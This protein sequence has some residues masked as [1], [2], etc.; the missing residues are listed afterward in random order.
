M[1]EWDVVGEEPLG[2]PEKQ[3]PNDPWAVVEQPKPQSAQPAAI[4][5]AGRNPAA[6]AEADRLAR[7]AG[8]PLSV[9]ERNPQ[10]LKRQSL[11][12]QAAE[13]P[14][15]LTS[16]LMRDPD[17]AAVSQDDWGVLSVLDTALSVNPFTAPLK[18]GMQIKSA[19]N[20]VR[21]GAAS[22]VNMAGSAIDGLTEIP[23]WQARQMER[24]TVGL[25]SVFSDEWA[26]KVRDN[27]DKMNQDYGWLSIANL[28]KGAGDSVG[29]AVDAYAK[30]IDVP[31]A[32]RDWLDELGAGA[33]SLLA[34]LGAG[35]TTG[36]VG[37]AALGA[38]VGV[39]QQADE[40]DAA[41]LY[42]TEQADKAMALGGAVSAVSESLGF[43]WLTRAIPEP[44]KKYLANRV[45]DIIQSGLGEGAQEVIENASQN[46]ITQRLI[47]PNQPLLEGVGTGASVGFTL[48]A[49][50]RGSQHVAHK[51][52]DSQSAVVENETLKEILRVSQS[53]KLFQMSPERY[54]DAVAALK[55]KGMEDVFVPVTEWRELFQSQQENDDARQRAGMS[56]AE[57]TAALLSN[58]RV[59]IPTESLMSDF[60]PEQQNALAKNARFQPDGIIPEEA[61]TFD[62]TAAM[63]EY[64]QQ[65]G[66]R[67][68]GRD[69]EVYDEFV[70]RLTGPYKRQEAEAMAEQYAGFV[71]GYGGRT[72]MVDYLVNA[73]IE[74]T[75]LKADSKLPDSM[76]KLLAERKDVVPAV[77]SILD[78]LRDR[79]FPSD[80]EMF[81]PT[82]LEAVRSWGGIEPTSFG[83]TDLAAMDAKR[84]QL[85]RSSDIGG[86]TMEDALTRAVAEGFINKRALSEMDQYDADAADIN[87]LIEALT[88]DLQGVNPVYS[89]QNANAA[90]QE[91]SRAAEDLAR[92]LNDKGIDLQKVDNATAR[93]M[94][95]WFTEEQDGGQ[96]YEQSD[97]AST[98]LGDAVTVEVDGIE[99]PAMNSN[100]VPIHDTV[101]G[102]RN[103]WRWFG[104]SKAVDA[105]G[106]PLV[107]YHGSSS[108]FERF[109]ESDQYYLTDDPGIA[110]EYADASGDNPNVMPLYS[111][112]KTP[113]EFD[114]GGANWANL[115]PFMVG[116][117]SPRVN[118]RDGT[119][120]LFDVADAA[121]AAGYDSV[122][123]KNVRDGNGEYGWNTPATV[124]IASNNRQMKSAT[125]NNGAFDPNNP[126]I[127]YQSAPGFDQTQTPEFKAWSNDA[128]LIKS[129]AAESYD[130]KTGEKI[131]VEAFHG[132]KRPDRVGVKF[133]KKRATSGPMAFHTSSPEVAS[134]YAQGKQDTSIAYEDTDYAN[135]FKVKLPGER[136]S[137]DIIRAWYGLSPEQK[138][139]IAEM[140]PKLT[141]GEE[142]Y[143]ADGNYVETP[144][145]V[146]EGNTQGLGGYD[147]EI[148]RTRTSW[149]R[150]GNPLKALVEG[151]LNGGS[152]FGQEDRFLKVLELAGFPMNTVTYDSPTSE[153]PFVYKN[154]IAMQNPLVT[155][156]IPQNVMDALQA[157]AK[158]DRSRA[159]S[160]GADMWDKNTRTL[161]EWV[162]HLTDP[163]NASVSYVWTSIP[164]K[165]TDVFRSLGY[166]GIVDWSGKSG[167]SLVAPVYIPFNETQ[168]K[169]A[170]GNKGAYSSAKNNILMQRK[171]NT[172]PRGSLSITDK[173]DFIIQL[174]KA[175]D[176]ST[177]LH[178]SGHLYLELM[179]E[180]DEQLRAAD[181]ATLSDSQRQ[182]LADHEAILRTLGVTAF[183]QIGRDQH[184]IFA[185]TY[186]AYLR[187]GN[188]PSQRLQS[189]FQKFGIWLKLIYRTLAGLP[190]Q[191]LNPEISE[192][193]NRMLAT[194]AEIAEAASQQGLTPKF[195]D[196][197][198]AGMTDVEYQQYIEAIDLARQRATDDEMRR[199]YAYMRQEEKAWWQQ[200]FMATK[201]EVAAEVNADPVY[202]AIAQM[203]HGTMPDG[204]PLPDNRKP[205]KLDTQALVDMY[206]RAFVQRHFFGMH[207]NE[208]VYP[209]VV[210]EGMGFS[211][212]DDMVTRIANAKPRTAYINAE[213]RR[214]MDERHPDPMS[215]PDTAQRAA[216][217]ANNEAAEQVL[218]REILALGGDRD[219]ARVMKESARRIVERTAI[220][221][222]K[223]NQY[224]IAQQSAGR[225]A[226]K[227]IAAGSKAEG[228]KALREQLMAGYMLR[229]ATNAV[230]ASEKTR[231]KAMRLAKKPAQERLAKA[232]G[233]YLTNVNLL[234]GSFEFR[235]LA[236]KD[237]DRRASLR[238]WVEDQQ[239]AGELT[240]VSDDLLARVEAER[241]TNWRDATPAQL[242]ELDDA[243]SNL[244][245]LAG[246]KNQLLSARDKA[247]YEQAVEAMIERLKQ[248]NPG[249]IADVVDEYDM[250]AGQK[251][252][253][254]VGKLVDE[255]TRPETV[256]EMMDGGESGPFHDYIWWPQEQSEAKI[257]E[258]QGRVGRMLIDLN[259]SVPK[260]FWKDLDGDVTV[261]TRRG[262]ATMK[263]YTLLSA[264]L[265]KGNET[266][267]QRLRDGGIT[268]ASGQKFE[269]TDGEVDALPG[270]LTA[271]ELAYVQGLWDI[272]GS[273][274]DD[275]EAMTMELGG[276]PVQFVE[277]KP[278]T[279]LSADGQQ[280]AMRGGYWPLV[281]HSDRS[282]VG[283]RQ[284]GDDALKVM[285]GM[286]FTRAA[287]SKGY[288]K[289]RVEEL[290]APLRLN[291]GYVLAKNLNDVMTDVAYRRTV[292]D[293][294][295]LLKDPRVKSEMVARMGEG[296]YRAVNGGLAYSV[297]ANSDAVDATARGWGG[298][299]DWLMSN[300][301]VSILGIRPDIALGNYTSSLVQGLTRVDK[302]ALMRGMRALYLDRGDTTDKIKA[303]SP[304]MANRLDDI[305][306]EYRKALLK[307]Q[308]KSGFR[309]AY[310]RVLMTLHRAADH[311]ATR[312]LWWG[313]Y[314]Q[315]RANGLDQQEAVRLADKTIRQ[316]QTT[317][318]RKDLSVFERDT[319]FKQSRMF[320]GPM[321]VI[322]GQ[323]RQAAGGSG[324]ASAGTGTRLALGLNALFFA[325]AMFALAAGRW[326]EDDDE[327]DLDAGDWAR[328][329]ATNTGL[330][331]AMQT[332]P[333]LREAASS[334][335]AAV[336][337]K[338]VNPRAAPSAQAAAQMVK[339]TKSLWRQADGAINGDDI[340]YDRL[341]ADLV[342]LTA[343]V[344][345]LPAS[346]WKRTQKALDWIEENPE[347]TYTEMARV[348]LYG[349]PK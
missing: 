27:I 245:H 225:E 180:V 146:E 313:R 323:I 119:T 282:A 166:D 85:F 247:D 227:A 31:E 94:M 111:A 290:R 216:Y 15:N 215:D 28:S 60:T 276:V 30:D 145:V 318:G 252:R 91:L 278:F 238:R 205:V 309:N 287:T 36:P 144:I 80:A 185:E 260:G 246:L 165:V 135:W 186:E 327:D 271:G 76:R 303:L 32:E 266:S 241:V 175:R 44:A 308:G 329:L 242:A 12:T 21:A 6:V 107:V 218:I 33:G 4:A 169:S 181:P 74:R 123:V 335:E 105:E 47:D 262:K 239:A 250:T 281:Y 53:S 339:A 115:S 285:M 19:P 195:K 51:V 263:R 201:E 24:A 257:H 82:L 269:L 159:R 10:E 104:D 18:Y 224:R 35:A 236:N 54:K 311:D 341:T 137:R 248:T 3:K 226:I 191:R 163:N 79:K 75:G 109:K 158:K 153:F 192:V 220:R 204:S 190:N 72:E 317:A 9:A 178:E 198:A 77:D 66:F 237:L 331:F 25:A 217:V 315:E 334:I 222:L 20:P 34:F 149:D 41:G 176:W 231:D 68:E 88:S 118:D 295:R 55:S 328:W 168:V 291:L 116:D 221:N 345:G 342:S 58:G 256:I 133:L 93:R 172:T 131:V 99:R 62:A 43:K 127:L 16:W 84:Q 265:N 270:L 138:D 174:G 338:P 50:L 101:E 126:S 194:D 134:G 343:P 171:R 113:Y 283:D 61:R 302:L 268:T 319:Q 275:I 202:I 8:V 162:G 187:D 284:A 45:A 148:A 147:W 243:L 110:N 57:Y 129:A 86:L 189:A 286:G 307:T 139:T 325:P 5:A 306:N 298:A 233:E 310:A 261:N 83:A 87:D 219:M 59:R 52:Q 143:D 78:M 324:V 2:T 177:F 234:L 348:M 69:N 206:G 81:G 244:T 299:A 71:R 140:A 251:V 184:E 279:I 182:V 277:S 280:V 63:K 40:A 212:A 213:A 210:A 39:D 128:P 64:M 156:D 108:Q 344:T 167:S 73:L 157:A 188:A 67:P 173:R 112:L 346:Q 223:P 337:D 292:R 161:K 98:P 196:A 97:R 46:L 235:R 106:R 193:F 179:R 294:Q 258:L 38:G 37:V 230:E 117:L 240:A 42:G 273:M 56:D 122:I 96:A 336:N 155:S 100:G 132:T 164:D 232:G 29:G 200:E 289:T 92:E 304:L 332:I 255:L 321:M 314:T 70:A 296:A 14:V 152:L 293:V 170:I 208:G 11:L 103:F 154:Y 320:M 151:W 288:T 326:P 95:G 228:L 65:A 160:G 142:V 199:Q 322:F 330:T 211:S 90:R 264:V 301:S 305:D 300:A 297:S 130:F 254:K 22:F 120:A 207:N 141:F 333:I 272:A 249:I 17:N 197:A 7:R 1:S 203:R 312:A 259:K 347:A 229:E 150:R 114:A 125:G 48:G 340:E 13:L 214:R 26:Q 49:F 349:P 121:F 23:A 274:R 136:S 253:G 124:Y 316:T 267:R 183:D 102:V 209:S 89:P